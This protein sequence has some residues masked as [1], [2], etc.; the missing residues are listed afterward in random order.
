MLKSLPIILLSLLLISC[1]NPKTK[2]NLDQKNKSLNLK[3]TTEA[4]MKE[5]K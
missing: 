4:E 5:N 1:E 3:I 2:K